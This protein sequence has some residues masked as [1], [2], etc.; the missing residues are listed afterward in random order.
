[1]VCVCVCARV[2]ATLSVSFSLLVDI[3]VVI[4]YPCCPVLIGF[5]ETWGACV[6]SY[7]LLFKWRLKSENARSCGGPV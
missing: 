5:L 7:C 4:A 1:M 2:H 3:L 6:D